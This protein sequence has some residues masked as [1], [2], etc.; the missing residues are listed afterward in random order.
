MLINY[1]TDRFNGGIRTERSWEDQ[2]GIRAEIRAMI[3]KRDPDATLEGY[4]RVEY[5]R[6]NGRRRYGQSNLNPRGVVEDPKRCVV[7]VFSDWGSHQCSNKRNGD[8]GLCGTHR[9][10]RE[11]GKNL[12][13][14][15]EGR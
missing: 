13:I 1:G 14:P 2:E 5:D 12:S 15:E 4:V 6:W 7:E 11:R 9:R 3:N 8:D 10:K